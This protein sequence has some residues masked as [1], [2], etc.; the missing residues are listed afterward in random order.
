[1]L[2][3]GIPGLELGPAP[4]FSAFLGNFESVSGS[5]F[6]YLTGDGSG[7]DNATRSSTP[8]CVSVLL[9]ETFFPG[10]I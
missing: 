3:I 6:P 9:D 8:V 7:L 2:K 5:S 1:M 4:A 10:W